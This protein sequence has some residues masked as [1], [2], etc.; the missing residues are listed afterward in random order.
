MKPLLLSFLVLTQLCFSQ[1]QENETAAIAESE[2][3]SASQLMSF[4]ANPNTANYDLLAQRLEL[5]LDPAVY[6]ISGTV[7]STFRAL[8]DMNTVVFD[9]SSITNPANPYYNNRIIVGSVMQ[10][11]NS[12]TFVHDVASKE[13]IITLPETLLAGQT[14]QVAISYAG[15]P[16]TAE[17]GF[18]QSSHSGVPVIWTLSE[19]FGARD[20]WPCKQD[21]NDKIENLEVLITAPSQYTSVSNG[22]QLSRID[23]GNGTSTTHFSHNYPIPAYLVAIAVT[24][25]SI[26]TQQA[27]TA[28]NEFPIVNY[29]YPENLN[30][31]QNSLAVTLPIMNLFE[32]LF[33]TYPFANEKYGHAQ[34]G[35]GGGMEHTTVSFMGSFGRNL[36][37]HELAHQ[38]FGNKIT[39]GTWKDIWL[40][41]GFATYLSGLVVEHLD[42][43]ENFVS[44][45]NS[46]ITNITSF[47]TGAVYL[48]DAE[49]TNVNRIFSSRLS[50]NK[51]A[52]VVHMLRWKLGDA[53]FYQALKNYLSDPNLAY[54]YARTSQ[55][56]FHL[57]NV[58]GMNLDEFFNDWLFNQGYPSYTITASNIGNNQVMITASQTQSH[59]SVSF[60]EM[61][62]E[63]R[64]SDANG[65]VW[66][67]VLEHTSNGQQFLVNA[68]FEVSQVMFDPK[69]HIISRNNTA[70]LSTDKWNLNASIVLHPNPT[71]NEF[72]IEIPNSLH[73][74]YIELH[75][76][77]GQII[78]R[79]TNLTHSLENLSNG[80][81]FVILHTTEGTFHKKLIK[82]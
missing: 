75:N 49:A 13:L 73:V 55:L 18:T 44:W 47:A 76:A 82:K 16:D 20:W 68:P 34:F 28:P 25:Y 27:G 14:A 52:M 29:I 6:F 72:S 56:K 43:P 79:S 51:G 61:P 62:I 53:L 8:T 17:Q 4:Q 26:F 7:S 41:E 5:T 74:N 64:L 1:N 59:S 31:A 70:I 2:M 22:V 3:K 80:V 60:F 37:A 78:L 12:L 63:V 32:D 45:K 66:D 38:W 40:N 36:I 24:N 69:K 57:E 19:P 46:L 48:T 35:W 9:L 10:N 50:Y 58:S 33:E 11:E 21:L 65:N 23:N 71:S 77:L 39:C 67:V 81:Y 15:A 30:S 42:G 54:N